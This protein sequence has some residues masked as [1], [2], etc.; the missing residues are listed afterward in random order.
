LQEAPF[1]QLFGKGGIAKTCGFW[2]AERRKISAPPIELA[3]LP[4]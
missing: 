3:V 2:S 1:L 4:R